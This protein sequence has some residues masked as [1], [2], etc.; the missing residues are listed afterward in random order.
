MEAGFFILLVA[1]AF[2]LILLRPVLQRQRRQRK[3]IVNLN[4]GDEVLTEAG[5]IAV[6]KEIQMTEAGSTILLLDLGQG[7]IVRALPTAVSQK[8]V[9]T[10]IVQPQEER[11]QGS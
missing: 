2:Y 6:V 9:I 5:F 3:D 7:V 4:V 8:L 10:P 11:V 1:G